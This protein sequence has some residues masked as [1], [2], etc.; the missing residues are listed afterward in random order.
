MQR[1]TISDR[2][3][4]QVFIGSVIALLPV[5][6]VV[7]FL[8]LPVSRASAAPAFDITL[9]STITWQPTDSLVPTGQWATTPKPP[10]CELPTSNATSIFP[11]VKWPTQQATYDV[12]GG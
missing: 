6:A 1:S 9:Q 12:G 5:M 7:L 4:R 2:R 3:R 11:T 8:S 10:L